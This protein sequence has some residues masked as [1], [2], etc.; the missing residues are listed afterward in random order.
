M[1]NKAVIFKNLLRIAISVFL[2]SMFVYV[3]VKRQSVY[4][5][6]EEYINWMSEHKV[7]GPFALSFMVMLGEI[8]FIPSSILTVG[9][10]F[11]LRRSFGNTAFALLYGTIACWL[12]ASIGAIIS[13][14][15][16]RFV[17]HDYAMKL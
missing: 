4:D 8:F 14:L 16:G 12:G 1:P 10:G 6:S 3:I 13:M 9:A 7:E 15:L 11:A 5:K 17:L 2:F